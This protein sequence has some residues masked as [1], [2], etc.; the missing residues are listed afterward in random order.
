MP[1]EQNELE[2]MPPKQKPQKRL[3]FLGASTE[4]ERMYQGRETVRFEIHG[5]VREIGKVYLDDDD[6]PVQDVVKVQVTS[7]KEL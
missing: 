6:V 4:G 1:P 5:Y 7:I 2:G 3:S